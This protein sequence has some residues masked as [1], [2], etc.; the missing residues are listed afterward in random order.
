MKTGASKP[1]VLL[2]LL[3]PTLDQG[4]SGAR[5]ERWRPSVAV[6]QHE[7]L[8]ISRY[9]MLHQ[10]RFESLAKLIEADIGSVSPE[11]KVRR[12]RIEMAD[13]VTHFPGFNTVDLYP[14]SAIV[15][16]SYL[17]G[18]FP[19]VFYKIQLYIETFF[20][21]QDHFT[22]LCSPVGPAGCT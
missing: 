1:L 18:A 3:G 19:A 16:E 12:H 8:L 5:W 6:C 4:K 20:S 10:A 15:H 11:T 9:E 14:L 7:N 2:G 13:H 17:S 22:V 21:L